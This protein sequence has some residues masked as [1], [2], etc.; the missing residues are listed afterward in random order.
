MNC[1]DCGNEIP[2]VRLDMI[3]DAE[4]CVNCADK[5]ATPFVA[6]MLFNH[7]TAGEVFIAKGTENVRRLNREYERAR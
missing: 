4:Y 6:R 1:L 2:K 5:N 3:P 7:K